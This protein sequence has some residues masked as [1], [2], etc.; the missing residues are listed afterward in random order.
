MN[1]F[2]CTTYYH[3]Y[4]TLLKQFAGGGESDAVICDDIPT[5]ERLAARLRETGIF[6]RVWFVEQSKFPE[7][8]GTG[9]LDRVLFQHRRHYLAVRPLVPFKLEDY[10][11][12]YIFH[13]GTPIGRYLTDAGRH[14]HLIEDSLNFYQVILESGQAWLLRPHNLKF[15]L[16]RLLNSGY[17]PLGESRYVTDVEV[18]E[19]RGLQLRL[20]RVVELP[21]AG[22]EERLTAGEKRLLLD[23]FECPELEGQ[24]EEKTALILTEPLFEDGLLLS[25]EEQLQTYRQLIAEM[26]ARGYEVLLKPHPRDRADYSGLGVRTLPKSFPTELFRYIPDLSFGCAAAVSSSALFWIP[27]KTR[28]LWR[29]GR[30]ESVQ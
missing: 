6:R 3:T 23:V 13:D 27:A 30:L 14:Y 2:I 9:P 24:T 17:F 19:A 18:N 1:L 5:G 8:M 15:R 16:R 26:Q 29:E 28:F 22:L 12:I 7:D 25:W 10:E 21:R 11:D 4:I 20:P